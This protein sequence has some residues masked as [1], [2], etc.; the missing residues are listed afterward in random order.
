MR[1][2]EIVIKPV[3]PLTPQQARINSLKQN[4]QRDKQQL[5]GERDRQRKQRDTE[6]LRKL[7]TP[8]PATV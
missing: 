8:S 3:A 5:Q 1:I 6:R 2:H 7:H 4:V